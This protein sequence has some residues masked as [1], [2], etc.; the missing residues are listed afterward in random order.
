MNGQA[1]TLIV[2]I[3]MGLISIKGS[4]LGLHVDLDPAKKIDFA[5]KR[6]VLMKSHIEM[7]QQEAQATRLNIESLKKV[8]SHNAMLASLEHR[9]IELTKEIEERMSDLKVTENSIK[10]LMAK[11]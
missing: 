1:K 7:K 2:A 9:L 6:M 4:A 5:Q 8:G 11:K 3:I 10:A